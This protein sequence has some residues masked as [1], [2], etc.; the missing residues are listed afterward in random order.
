MLWIAV[1]TICFCVACSE[2]AVLRHISSIFRPFP[3]H[4]HKRLQKLKVLSSPEQWLAI[5][6]AKTD[7]LRT[8]MNFSESASNVKARKLYVETLLRFVTGLVYGPEEVSAVPILGTSV[9]NGAPVDDEQKFEG[10]VWTGY[11]T[12]MVGVHRLRNIYNLLSTIFAE[13]VHG[14]FLEAGV[15]RGGASVFARGIMRILCL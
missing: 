3:P 12:T 13:D 10:L 8:I 7:K 4:T 11:G 6:S 2:S 9:V 15:W 1:L 5:Y 14:G